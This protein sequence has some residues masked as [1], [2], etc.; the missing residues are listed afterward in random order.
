MPVHGTTYDVSMFKGT[1]LV[2]PTSS[3]GMSGMIAVEL[4]VSNE[5]VIKA[6]YLL[7]EYISP[8]VVND[9]LNT[10]AEGAPGAM[11]MPCEV[12]V[13]SDKAYTFIILRSGI[14]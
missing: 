3:A 4:F 14:C 12:Y 7:S 6:G 9:S 11:T 10:N 2:L 8:M 1:T 13:S 5:S